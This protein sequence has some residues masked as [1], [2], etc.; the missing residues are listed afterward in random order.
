MM[1]AHHFEKMLYDNAKPSHLLRLVYQETNYPLYAQRIEETVTW[2]EREIIEEGGGF[3]W[4]PRCQQRGRKTQVLRH[5]R[6]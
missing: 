3:R 5:E 6:R 2:L 1:L 4:Q